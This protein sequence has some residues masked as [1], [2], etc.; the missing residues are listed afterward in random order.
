MAKSKTKKN[1]MY[2]LSVPG[3]RTGEC[4]RSVQPRTLSNM[5]MEDV[6]NFFILLNEIAGL[7][8]SLG[9]EA[10]G[11]SLAEVE[12]KLQERLFMVSGSQIGAPKVLH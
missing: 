11:R 12:Y 6:Q 8:H 4:A 2:L 9:Y 7:L 10:E 3:S 5:E 1:N